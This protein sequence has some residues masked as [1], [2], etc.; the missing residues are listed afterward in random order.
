M[1]CQKSR[2]KHQPTNK[3]MILQMKLLFRYLSGVNRPVSHWLT[4]FTLGQGNNL[5]WLVFKETKYVKCIS[6]YF[7]CMLTNQKRNNSSQFAAE[8]LPLPQSSLAHD[9]RS[10]PHRGFIDSEWKQM[11][12]C[13]STV[14]PDLEQLGF[15]LVF[16][17]CLFKEMHGILAAFL[18][19]LLVNAEETFSGSSYPYSPRC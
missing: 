18:S 17:A 15:F 1:F 6:I 12:M 13:I 9:H 19:Y 4:D 10:K 3:N 5:Q 11:G 14:A 8:I 7:L 16:F 2:P